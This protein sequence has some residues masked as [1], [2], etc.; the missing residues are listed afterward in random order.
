MGES[1]L[2]TLPI[3]GHGFKADL[4]LGKRV[5]QTGNSRGLTQKS[6]EKVGDIKWNSIFLVLR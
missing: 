6:G 2:G 3:W 4:D 1:C 5:E